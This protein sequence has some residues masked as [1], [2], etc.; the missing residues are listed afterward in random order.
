[1]SWFASL[2]RRPE[3]RVHPSDPAAAGLFDWFGGASTSG[4]TVTE[5]AALTNMAV[6]ACVRVIAD[7]I[8]SLPLI[9]YQR[10]ADGGKR[11]NPNHDLYTILHD[12]PNPEMSSFDLRETLVGHLC[13]WGNGYCEIDWSP[14][15]V[16]RGLWPLRP[17]RMAVQ[18]VNGALIY[19]Y[20]LDSGQG[21]RLPAW[22]MLHLRGLG[23][24]GLIGYSRI[25]VAMNAI[26]LALAAEEFGARLF[27]NGARPSLVYQHPGVLSDKA[28]ANLQKSLNTEMTG[29]SNMHRIKILEEGMTVEKIGIPPDEAQ[30]LETRRY[31]LLDI[32]RLYGVPPH[33]IGDQE[34]SS[35]SNNEQAELEFVKHTVRP[36]LVRI[37][38]SIHRSLMTPAERKTVF[39]EFLVDGLLRG[40]QTSRYQAYQTGIMSGFLSRNE[41]RMLENM[42]PA[43]DLD[44]YLIPLNMGIAGEP[45]P[46]PEPAPEPQPTPAPQPPTR[47]ERRAASDADFTALLTERQTLARTYFDLMEDAARRLVRREVADL[48]RA[49]D[50]H[51]RQRSSSDFTEFLSAF[52]DDLKPV[53]VDRF[54]PILRTLARQ[55]LAL[56]AA[57]L[58][59]DAP[60]TTERLAEFIDGY[61]DN[62]AGAW[63]AISEGQLRA[64]LDRALTEST[65]PA[66]AIEER[67]TEWEDTRPAKIAD[68]ES[69]EALN[70]L[71]IFGYRSH[72]V[73]YLRWLASGASCQ[74]C[75]SL[76]GKIAGIDEYFVH[77]GDELDDPDGGRMVVG[78]NKQHGPLHRGCDCIVVGA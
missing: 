71:A 44:D 58:A 25:R 70:A 51:L 41:V 37:E 11:R 15:G 47:T 22:R 7:T 66:D 2:L 73:T 43:E 46:P 65:D 34:H 27:A 78:R 76:S 6:F 50:K 39:V 24:D 55:V 64:I 62:F 35:Y 23:F 17:D 72:G 36:W 9:T 33:M 3:Q 4:V 68:R 8:A 21:V 31:Q 19:D 59:T 10:N 52:Y 53:L 42:N 5:P 45:L 28:R 26:G 16:V 67:L 30:F 14:S 29:L 54:K 75:L 60:I 12:A 13:T 56:V 48:R 61:L 38:Q 63:A 40:D 18:R 49:V 74:F 20:L 1:M 32:A 57:E 77:A 69:F